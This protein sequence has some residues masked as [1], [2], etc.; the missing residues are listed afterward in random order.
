MLLGAALLLVACNAP[1]TIE[2]MLSEAKQ[3][4]RKGDRKSAAILLKNVLQQN[5]KR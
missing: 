4:H 2:S 3:Y 1:P 5:P